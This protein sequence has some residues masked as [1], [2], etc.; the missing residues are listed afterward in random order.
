MKW[1]EKEVWL[2]AEVL[3][4]LYDAT[5]LI[6]D[7]NIV[8]PFRGK[9]G[10]SLTGTQFLLIIIIKQMKKLLQQP[11]MKFHPLQNVLNHAVKVKL[12]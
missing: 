12:L 5:E 8:V 11:Q 9:G 7:A 10:K 3:D 2:E 4:K 1:D 6:N